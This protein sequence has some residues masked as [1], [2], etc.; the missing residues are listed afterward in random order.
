MTMND[1]MRELMTE[2]TTGVRSLAIN[3]LPIL[4]SKVWLS[5]SDEDRELLR[6][7]VGITFVL[8]TNKVRPPF[9]KA[10]NDAHDNNTLSKAFKPIRARNEY[11]DGKTPGKVAASAETVVDKA[12]AFLLLF[13]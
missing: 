12:L 3:L 7:F 8:M 13:E 10:I 6:K 5:W 9:D 2:T 11:E 4:K 1:D